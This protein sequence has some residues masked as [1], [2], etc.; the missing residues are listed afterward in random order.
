MGVRRCCSSAG[1][2]WG[3]GLL[4]A[5]LGWVSRSAALRLRPEGGQPGR[6]LFAT[7]PP[8]VLTRRAV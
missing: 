6:S 2:G 1:G 8:K 5:K 4:D 7:P 3:R